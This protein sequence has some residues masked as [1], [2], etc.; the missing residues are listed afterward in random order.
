MTK[1]IAAAAAATILAGTAVGALADDRAGGWVTSFD[2]TRL[3]LLNDDNVYL[4]G[5]SVDATGVEIMNPAHVTYNVIDGRNVVTS[6][7][8]ASPPAVDLNA[9]DLV[10]YDS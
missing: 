3:T 10:N 5:P 8:V 7:T 1:L 4:V 6:I 2:G 9:D